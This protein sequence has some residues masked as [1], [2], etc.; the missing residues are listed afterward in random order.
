MNAKHA[1]SP[2]PAGRIARWRTVAGLDFHVLVTLLFRGWG[3]LAGAVTM[4]VL[5]WRLD[6]VEQGYYYTFGS[7]LALQVFF[8]LG[9]NQV[10]MQLVS[11]EVAHLQFAD[12]HLLG[13]AARL[14]RL[15]ALVRLM[16]RWY[17]AAALLFAVVGAV[18]GI[19][20]F[21]RKGTLPSSE[22]TGVW[23]VLVC[24]T[25]LNLFMSP[26]LAMMEG[27]GMVGQVARLRLLQ[28]LAGSALLWLLLFAGAGLWA[29]VAVPAVAAASTSW[30]L[31]SRGAVLKRVAEHRP[32]GPAR[33]S[34]RRDVLP[35]QW[36]I[37]LS[38]ASGYFIFNL[39]TP[40]VFA[41]HGAAEAGRLG[42]AMAI[43]NA[44]TTVGLSWINAKAPT[45]TMHISR[46]ESAALNRLFRAVALRSIVVTAAIAFSVVAVDWFAARHGIAAAARVAPPDALFW[47]AW[48]TVV[49]VIV[50]AAA[51]YMRA[52]RE[53][54]MVPVSV[55][56]GL[57]T[58][59]MLYATAASS[60]ATMMMMY[61]AIG[62]LV[63]LP[64]T[65]LLF[66]RYAQRHAAP[67][68]A[69]HAPTP[70]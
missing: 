51:T 49:N 19:V 44:V 67:T 31:Q 32:P 48:A 41:H 7:V 53:E 24:S 55:V 15:G 43:F 63:G 39:F 5:P 9:L 2:A 57:L 42:I 21:S 13:D 40:I 62:T 69:D 35:L 52:H 58:V 11:H 68:G 50:Y 38:W 47:L 33:A 36:R 27:C 12:G 14:E 26:R 30:W 10:V 4:I 22:W 64:W 20:F 34:W 65:A 1:E 54:P 56:A 66:R 18:A 17:A 46:G 61:A 59:A 23:A 6:P 29:A 37:A 25:A 45:F 16:R 3:I 28:S 60:L 70:T 8:E